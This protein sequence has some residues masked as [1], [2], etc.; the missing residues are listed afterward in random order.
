MIVSIIDDLP[1]KVEVWKYG[2]SKNSTYT[3]HRY[4]CVLE[5][6]AKKRRSTRRIQES[7]TRRLQA[8]KDI[9]KHI[10]ET[11]DFYLTHQTYRQL[12]ESFH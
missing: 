10:L 6:Y 3:H 8:G 4:E 1:A 7:S 12:R 11:S 2:L 9:C 5:T